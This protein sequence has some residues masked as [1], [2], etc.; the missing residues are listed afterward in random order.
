MVLVDKLAEK[1]FGVIKG[2]GHQIKLYTVDG[3]ETVD[4]ADARRFFSAD[5][6]LMITIDEENNEVQLSK[7]NSESI[8]KN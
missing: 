5:S 6:G 1:L 4:P 7:S 3:T 8:D 2:F